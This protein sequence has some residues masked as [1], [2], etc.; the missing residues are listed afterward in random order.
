MCVSVLGRLLQMALKVLEIKGVCFTSM[1]ISILPFIQYKY[2]H[3]II[4]VAHPV[5]YLDAFSVTL[6]F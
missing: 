2:F 4:V 3:L 6:V 1:S 5:V